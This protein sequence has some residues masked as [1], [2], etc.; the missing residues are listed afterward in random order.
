MPIRSHLDLVTFTTTLHVL[1]SD[2]S[3]EA[4]AILDHF[5]RKEEIS[6][7][8][9]YALL[10]TRRRHVI[11]HENFHFWQAIRLPFLLRHGL[12]AIS[13]AMQAFRQLAVASRDFHGWECSLTLQDALRSEWIVGYHGDDILASR[14][15]LPVPNAEPFSAISLL[16]AAA[17]LA[18]FLY[19]VPVD[20]SADPLALNRWAKTNPA[21][22]APY[23]FAVGYLQ[24][25][26]I[27]LRLLLPL[28]NAAFCTT[29]PVRT[30]AELLAQTKG[31]LASREGQ[32][33]LSQREPCRWPELFQALLDQLNYEG[34]ECGPTR[35]HRIFLNEWVGAE[36]T[37][38][39]GNKFSH[40][41]LSTTAKAW[42]EIERKLPHLSLVLDLPQFSPP[43]L[44]ELLQDKY[45]CPFSILVVHLDSG[46]VKVFTLTN[47]EG[48]YL[49]GIVQ[50]V[51]V[52]SAVRR[53]NRQHFDRDLRI[54]RHEYCPEYNANFC[55]GYPLIPTTYT[56]CRFRERLD[57]YVDDVRRRYGNPSASSG[58][59][60]N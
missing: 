21:Y 42:L 1:A 47:L 17:S 32:Q 39:A 16:E 33:C 30:F 5:E 8:E 43:G 24:N 36:I 13:E 15:P 31:F 10:P 45:A 3:A 9:L 58:G 59:Q 22:L 4:L 50:L 28:L 35:Y 49:R 29:S 55:N 40:P 18:E 2:L 7:Q 27:A 14:L 48:E 34:P 19:S 11:F 60:S 23:R 57:S 25:E 6:P 53:A 46:A 44:L 54:C 52:Y 56:N 26:A 38:E 37:T 41:I 51:T 20:R 12:L